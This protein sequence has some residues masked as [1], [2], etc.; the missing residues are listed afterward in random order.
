MKITFLGNFEVEYSS[1]SQHA[2]TLEKMGHKVQRLQ[3]GQV[4]SN[5]IFEFASK[6]D[7]FI[8]IHTHGWL[9]PGLTSMESVL[10]Q[11]KEENI[12]TITYHLDLWKGLQ[13]EGDLEMDPFYK[14]IGHFFATDKLMADWFNENTTV[15]GHYLPAGIFEEET[16]MLDKGETKTPELV[17]VGSKGYHSE[18]PYRPQLIDWLQKTY[19][20]NFGHYSG[21]EG[22]LGLKRGLHLNQ[23][24]ADTKVVVGDSLCL[25]FNYPHYW[26][27]RVY[28]IIG[29][30]G[31]LIMPYIQGLDDYFEDGKHL[32]FYEY[33]DFDD[34]KGKIDFYL[35]N[36]RAREYIRKQGFELVKSRDTY[37]DRWQEI[38]RVL[39]FDAKEWNGYYGKNG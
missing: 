16:L 32:V 13:R 17:F 34:L 19:G 1:E 23:L 33:G 18:W 29:R 7:L 20:D 28:E 12:P 26:S 5:L 3:E 31:F 25:N 22:T 2:K 21:E 38:L 30:G 6:S 4:D 27:D 36:D 24:L 8:W 37:T 35:S 39:G 15:E 14:D 10:R 9:T 11:L